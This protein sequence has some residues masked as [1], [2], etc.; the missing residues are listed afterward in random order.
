[1]TVTPEIEELVEALA[2]L[3]D[4]HHRTLTG[5]KLH[6]PETKDFWDC[7]CLTC[8]KAVEIIRKNGYDP[9]EIIAP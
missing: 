4:K 6:D 3:A 8:K 1:M 5:S 2:K 9:K 7:E